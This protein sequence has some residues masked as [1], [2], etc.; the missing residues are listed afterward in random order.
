VPAAYFHLYGVVRDD[1]DYIMDTFKVVRER[2][3]K[4]YG[5]FRTKRM[6]L[7]IFD[8]MQ[9]AIDTGKPYTT[10]VDPPPGHGARHPARNEAL[11]CVTA[12]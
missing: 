10:I 2:D 12:R 8:A 5:E 1:V 11:A 6:I 3:E 7:E 4:T 9:R